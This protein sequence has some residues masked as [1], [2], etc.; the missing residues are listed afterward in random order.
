[1]SKILS[2][3]RLYNRQA[4]PFRWTYR[5][6]RKRIHVSPISVTRHYEA[7]LILRSACAISGEGFI[8]PTGEMR[9][10]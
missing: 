3:V 4:Q 2:Y 9:Q 8:E 10:A 7:T 5:N 1:V 6:P